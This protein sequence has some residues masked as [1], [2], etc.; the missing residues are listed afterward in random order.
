MHNRDVPATLLQKHNEFLETLVRIKN[1]SLE[2]D[3][4]EDLLEEL[5]SELVYFQ[6]TIMRTPGIS[7]R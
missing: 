5:M 2:E 1:K 3:I 7:Y 6:K 4:R